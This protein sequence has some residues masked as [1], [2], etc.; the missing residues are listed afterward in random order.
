M[1]GLKLVVLII[2]CGILLFPQNQDETRSFLKF[3]FGTDISAVREDISSWEQGEILRSLKKD[4]KPLYSTIVT[5]NAD[6]VM[7]PVNNNALHGQEHTINSRI[8]LAL[9]AGFEN[10]CPWDAQIN[11]FSIVY[12]PALPVSA[13]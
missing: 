8:P 5:V 1:L 2:N 10:V 3:F 4:I 11:P 7:V 9:P 12:L 13:D 6:P